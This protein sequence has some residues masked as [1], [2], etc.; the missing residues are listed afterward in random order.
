MGDVGLTHPPDYMITARAS[1][2]PVA[3][4]ERAAAVQ[5]ERT[6]AQ[7]QQVERTVAQ[8][9]QVRMVQQASEP[10]AQA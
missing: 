6:V 7:R 9:Q 2:Q 10:V 4:A 1:V 8:R 3:L 5:A